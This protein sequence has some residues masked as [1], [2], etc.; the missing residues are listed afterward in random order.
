MLLA[1]FQLLIFVPLYR[2]RASCK[3]LVEEVCEALM[4]PLD[5]EEPSSSP[6]AE[7]GDVG[8]DDMLGVDPVSP[9]RPSAPAPHKPA[10]KR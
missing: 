1:V 8:S 10:A 5:I 7:E 3:E 4:F 2:Y 9:E 6:V